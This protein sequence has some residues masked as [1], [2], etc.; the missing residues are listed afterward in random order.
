MNTIE[1][2]N[3]FHHLIDSINNDNILSKFYAIMARMNERADGKLW[4]RL[5]EEEQE[6]LIRAD[7]ESNDPSNLISHTEIQKKHKKWL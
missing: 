2:R 4:G 5:T 7:I 1:L 3:N 6:E